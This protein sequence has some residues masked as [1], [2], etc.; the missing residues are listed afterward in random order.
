MINYFQLASMNGDTLPST[1]LNMMMVCEKLYS[2]VG[3]DTLPSTSTSLS[4]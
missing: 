3:A 1:S 2:V 4:L